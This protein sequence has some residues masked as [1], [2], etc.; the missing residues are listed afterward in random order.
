MS[1]DFRPL[2]V[3]HDLFRKPLTT[4]RDHALATPVADHSDGDRSSVIGHLDFSA[5]AAVMA[6]LLA[7]AIFPAALALLARTPGLRDRNAPQFLAATVLAVGIWLIVLGKA[8]NTTATAAA[9]ATSC[10]ILASALLVYL[11]IWALLTTGYTI[12]LLITLLHCKRPVTDA[13]LAAG[14]RH[15]KGLGWIMRSRMSGLISARLVRR[16]GDLIVLTPGG[17]IV[18]ILSRVAMTV[19]SLKVVG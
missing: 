8:T 14:Y 2:F 4:F 13:E 19:F 11:E 3:E 17:A 16:Q 15:G 5:D 9:L 6:A 12:G 7:L 18:A 10:M 1:S